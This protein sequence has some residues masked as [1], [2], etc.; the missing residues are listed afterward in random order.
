MLNKECGT[1]ETVMKNPLKVNFLP[2]L[3]SLI[4]GREL[5]KESAVN[6]LKFTLAQDRQ[7]ISEKAT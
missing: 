6:K 5:P 1:V 4:T 3:I 2:K 7:K